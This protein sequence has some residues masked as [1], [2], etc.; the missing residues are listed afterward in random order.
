MTHDILKIASEP[1][2][3]LIERCAKAIY[4]TWLGALNRDTEIPIDCP[5][6]VLMEVTREKFRAQARACLSEASSWITEG[7]KARLGDSGKTEVET[8]RN[9]ER[10]EQQIMANAISKIVVEMNAGGRKP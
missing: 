6:G 9:S 8:A 10:A 5:W 3:D 4:E 1:E 7:I 2:A